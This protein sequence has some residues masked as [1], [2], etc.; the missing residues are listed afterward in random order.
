[1]WP[2]FIVSS[3]VFVAKLLLVPIDRQEK[4]WSIWG[5]QNVKLITDEKKPEHCLIILL[6][7]NDFLSLA[8]AHWGVGR[9]G[10]WR[11]RAESWLGRFSTRRLAP[12]K[13]RTSS[14]W[15]LLNGECDWTS[16]W[17][18][19]ADG[20][21]GRWEQCDCIGTT[22]REVVW[23]NDAHDL[24]K[25]VPQ[26]GQNWCPGTDFRP[27][28]A[29]VPVE[30]RITTEDICPLSVTGSCRSVL[31]TASCLSRANI[32]LKPRQE[33]LIFTILS[34]GLKDFGTSCARW[35]VGW[36][37]KPGKP[38]A[39]DAWKS[40]FSKPISSWDFRVTYY[41]RWGPEDPS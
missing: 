40:R 4:Q 11:T 25:A 22:H 13:S 29:L 16:F 1:M 38:A 39:L 28:A 2:R 24:D 27:S 6:L 15:C 20:M 37:L 36:R 31:V 30:E 32:I 19:P 17:R 33:Y 34:T 26:I 9:L 21:C 10:R 14:Y 41:I 3:Q 8:H 35:D 18:Q 12:P 7:R 23:T 5:V